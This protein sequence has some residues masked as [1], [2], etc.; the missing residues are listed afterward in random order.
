MPTARHLWCTWPSKNEKK[1]QYIPKKVQIKAQVRVILFNKTFTK[2]PVKYSNYS[3][4]FLVKYTAKLL[5]NT[6]INKHVIKLEKDKQPLFDPIYSQKLIELET[7]KIYIKT[8][9]IN[10]FIQSFKSPVKASILFDRKSDK[11]FCFLWI[12]RILTTSLS[13]T[14]IYYFWLISYWAKQFI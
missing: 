11:S 4:V 6:K 3:N 5:E 14:N 1:S 12:I 9:L 8:N 13:K 7:L 10:N 2:V